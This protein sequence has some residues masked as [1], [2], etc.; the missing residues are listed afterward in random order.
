MRC[1]YVLIHGRLTWTSSVEHETETQP[2]GFYCHRYVLAS[3]QQNAT[4]AA[5]ARVL[6]NL[7]TQTGWLTKS[8]VAVE[9]GAEE[10]RVAPLHKLLKADNGGHTFYIDE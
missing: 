2:S 7:D 6:A 4:D 8:S 5:F 1:F 9:L 10:V 3:N